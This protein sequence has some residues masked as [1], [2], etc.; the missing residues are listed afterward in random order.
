MEVLMRDFDPE[1]IKKNFAKVAWVYDFWAWLTESKS[2]K[3]V[4]ELCEVNDGCKI[5]DVAV[6]TG[7]LFEKLV[8]LNPNGTNIGIDL[9]PVML[10]KAKK[11]MEKGKHK[12]Y[13]LQQG[14]ALSLEFKVE[15]FDILINNFM[16]DLMPTE[17]FDKIISEFYRVLKADGITVISTF[18]FGYKSIHRLWY[19][20]AKNFPDL[21]TGCRPVSIKEN[22]KN[23]GFAIEH[24]EQIS[25]NTFPSEIV[26]ARK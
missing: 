26:K 13:L 18:S 5:L 22:L 20:M 7:M 2:T 14:D 16:I 1:K 17:Y 23:A 4:I 21:L 25:Q 24:D 9:S 12:N 15:S 6:G 8:S 11:R 10:E 19:R 3:R